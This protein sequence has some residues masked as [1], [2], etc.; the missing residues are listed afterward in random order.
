MKT[1]TVGEFKTRF[2]KVFEQVKSGVGFAITYHCK[3]EVVGY[4]LPESHANK[5]IRKLGLLEGKV[6]AHFKTNFK[7]TE[8]DLLG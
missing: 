1:I 3:K 5:P 7:M 2:A 8:E 4:F 6:K